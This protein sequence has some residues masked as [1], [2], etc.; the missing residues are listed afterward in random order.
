MFKPNIG[1]LDQLGHEQQPNLP[2]GLYDLP[3]PTQKQNN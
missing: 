3:S 1:A 2:D